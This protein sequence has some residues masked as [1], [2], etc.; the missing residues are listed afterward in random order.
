MQLVYS[1]FE[2]NRSKTH[3][4]CGFR[5]LNPYMGCIQTQWVWFGCHSAI[6]HGFALRCKVCELLDKS[7][8]CSTDCVLVSIVLLGSVLC[9]SCLGIT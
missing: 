4:W 3:T 1:L 5:S 6:W 2:A 8:W 7:S 9:G